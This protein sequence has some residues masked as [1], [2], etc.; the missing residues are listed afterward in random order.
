MS[1]PYIL[2]V[3]PHTNIDTNPTM[4]FLLESLAERRVR[5]NILVGRDGETCLPPEPFG[6][7]IQ[8]TPI[9]TWLFL[10]QP[11]FPRK[12]LRLAKL[13]S[14]EGRR[15]HSVRFDP[16]ML[17]LWEA[18]RY[19]LIVGVDPE[20]IIFADRISQGARKPL[21]YI[22]FEIMFENEMTSPQEQAVKKMELAASRRTALALV[23]D[24]ERAQAFACET[25]IPER[26]MVLVPVAPPPQQ[27]FKSNS[28]RETL[29]IPAEKRVVLYPGSLDSWASRDEFAEMVSYWPEKYCLVLHNRARMNG[30]MDQYVR[31]LTHT[32]KIYVSDEPVPRERMVDLVASA[33]FGLAPYKLI[34]D[35]WCTVKNLY[36]LGLSSGKVSFYA[37]CGL[38]IL[39]RALPV[40][41]REFSKYQCG[42]I[43]QRLSETG[44]ILEEMDQNY[45]LH[46]DEARRFY[47]ERINPKKGME[48]FCQQL[49]ELASS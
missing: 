47:R 43:Y 20:G 14:V 13:L 29:G 23:Q 4:T 39:A 24:E 36:H 48:N 31:D 42:R 45:L 1:D 33:D 7:T 26:K 37:L 3:Y 25:S 49:L 5:V 22:S 38:P 32:G 9:P 28:L 8:L 16:G 11:K 35:S 15:D 46:S 17:G 40:F 18:R 10:D 2:I 30:R 44:R 6:K 34:P 12:L 19:S 21:V 41:E 27:V